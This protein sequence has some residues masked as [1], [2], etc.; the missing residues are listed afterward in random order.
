MRTRSHTRLLCTQEVDVPPKAPS[1]H[2]LHARTRVDVARVNVAL[3]VVRHQ[4]ARGVALLDHHEGDGGVVACA[5][6]FGAGLHNRAVL[7]RQNLQR[8]PRSVQAH[9][10]R[11]RTT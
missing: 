1:L 8:A 2:R 5:A 9:A 3:A 6:S 11:G 10:R 4:Q 7:I